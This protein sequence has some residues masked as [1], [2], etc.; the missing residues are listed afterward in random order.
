METGSGQILPMKEVKLLIRNVSWLLHTH[1]D[2]I[3][4]ND[5]PESRGEYENYA[6]RI[7]GMIISNKSPRQI[8]SEL[9]RIQVEEMGLN[10]SLGEN[11]EVVKRI[12]ADPSVDRWR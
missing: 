12:L 7:A 10:S 2:P 9:D 1:W 8:A 4:V 11:L 3:G 6:P 5:D